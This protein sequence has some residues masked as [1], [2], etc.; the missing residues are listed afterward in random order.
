MDLRI[1]I[2]YYHLEE[3]ETYLCV[4]IDEHP[5]WCEPEKHA[6]DEVLYAFKKCITN[7]IA[8]EDDEGTV[9]ISDRQW[10]N[11]LREVK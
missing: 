1:G 2:C 11:Q 10:L 3:K 4:K 5:Q 9:Y 6:K 8:I 7:S